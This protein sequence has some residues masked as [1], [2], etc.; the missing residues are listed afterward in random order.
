MNFLKTAWVRLGL[1]FLA[2]ILLV[3]FVKPSTFSK[4]HTTELKRWQAPDSSALPA[5]PA[6]DL[7]R[8]GRDLIVR[9]AYYLGPKGRVAAIT[10]GM[11]CQNC[12]LA[13]GTQNWG[14]PFSAVASTYPKY[15][16]RSGQIESIEFRIN[17]CLTRSLN[18]KTIDSGSRE[19]QAMVAYMKWLGKDVPKGTKP[20]GSGIEPLLF[21]MRAADTVNGKNV[22][23]QKCQSCHGSNG[24]GV[25]TADSGSFIYPPLWGKQSYNNGA[26]LYRLF[27]FATYVKYNMPFGAT[28]SKPQLSNE[29]AWD[30]AAFVNSRPRP[31]KSFI[32]DWPRLFQK[33]IDYPFGPYT[34]SFSEAQHKYGPFGVMERT[35]QAFKVGSSESRVRK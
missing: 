15:R 2:L 10:N 31:L 4:P 35:S 29:E 1:I 27:Q 28:Y 20:P 5:T 23:I 22:Y 3:I 8:Y 33:P 16:P 14:N 12:H 19:M 13:A 24:Q 18:G 11:N 25:P 9:T 7:I 6:G 26:G 21:L 17:D 30:V 32:T 34:D